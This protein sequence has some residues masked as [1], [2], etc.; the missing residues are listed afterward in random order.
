M[1]PA[2]APGKLEP[3]LI[4]EHDVHQ[5]NLRPEFFCPAQRLSRGSGHADDAQALPFQAIAGGPQ[6]QPVVVHNQDTERCH[7]NSV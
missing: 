1:V 4:P 7:M 3:A 5:G 6:K 2:Q